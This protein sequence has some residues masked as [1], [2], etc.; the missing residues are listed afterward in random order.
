MRS[1]GEFRVTTGSRLCRAQSGIRSHLKQCSFTTSMRNAVPLRRHFIKER[2]L[3]FC[4]L[5]IRIQLTCQAL[6][7]C[8]T[9]S[10]AH[11]RIRWQARKQPYILQ[12][13]TNLQLCRRCYRFIRRCY[14]PEQGETKCQREE[15][16]SLGD[17]YL[18]FIFFDQHRGIRGG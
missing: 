1:C 4:P 8:R 16:K 6:L 15:R 14:H 3:R 13:V 10:I 12:S 2:T 18:K 9:A 5:R 11:H 7:A 17:F